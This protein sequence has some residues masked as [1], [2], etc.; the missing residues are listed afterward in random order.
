M[1][2]GKLSP[3]VRKV[4]PSRVEEGADHTPP[5]GGNGTHTDRDITEEVVSARSW[6]KFVRS[7]QEGFWRE[8]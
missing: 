2:A 1:A 5:P 4:P 3:Q 6:D 7:F 8:T